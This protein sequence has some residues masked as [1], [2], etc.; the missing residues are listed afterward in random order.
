MVN[1]DSKQWSDFV[2][3][4][5]HGNIFQTPEIY[6]I[7]L[8]EDKYEPIFI[9]TEIDDRLT[10]ILLAVIQKEHAG[11]LGKFS[12]RS[13][14]IGGPLV[15]NNDP[16]YLSEIL[17]KYSKTLENKV[18]YTQFRNLWDWKESKAIF[19]EFGYSYVPHLDIL[20]DVSDINKLEQGISKNKKRNIIKSTNKGLQFKDITADYNL[21]LSVDLIQSTYNRI[22]LPC[23]SREYFISAFKQLIPSN[24]LKVFGAFIN[25]KIV[26][27]RLELIF[28]DQIYDWYAGA[29]ENE[30]NK[31]P[32]DFLIYN[33]LIW[34]HNN[35]FKVF[36][37]G[38]AGKPDKP[39]GVREHKLKFSNNLVE[40]G[41]FEKI[42]N[43]FLWH[44][45]KFGLQVFKI[46]KRIKKS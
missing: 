37:F 33:V 10:G 44:I 30:S 43:H 17:N 45:G 25:D 12:A 39:Y 4:H 32:N 24:R 8:S 29:D 26:G 34:G 46:I 18:I 21:G 20:I 1:I 14:V 36:D 3:Q 42:N 9:T 7:Y 22:G 31:Y 28:K 23:M 5:P 16:A 38:G 40:F 15:E 27:T 6:Q 13:I 35:G 41:R 19:K 2:F 11:I